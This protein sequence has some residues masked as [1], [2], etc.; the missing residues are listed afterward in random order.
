MALLT[1]IGTGLYSVSKSWSIANKA[2][3]N[4]KKESKVE[5]GIQ[6]DKSADLEHSIN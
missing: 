2:A 1:N 5:L 3:W 4:M 6:T